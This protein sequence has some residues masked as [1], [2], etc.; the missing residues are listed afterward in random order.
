[1]KLQHRIETLTIDG[2]GHSLPNNDKQLEEIW[3][4]L[5]DIINAAEKAM[6]KVSQLR[7]QVVAH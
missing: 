7:R 3:D 1:M 6:M 4:E 2:V 5:D